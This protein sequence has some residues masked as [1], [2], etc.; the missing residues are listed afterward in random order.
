MGGSWCQSML[1]LSLLIS[2]IFAVLAYVWSWLVDV[3]DSRI[4][5]EW[6]QGSGMFWSVWGAGISTAQR[7]GI[8]MMDQC[9]YKQDA[10]GIVTCGPKGRFYPCKGN[11][12]V[13]DV[14]AQGSIASLHGNMGIGH[15]ISSWNVAYC[16]TISHSRELSK[17]RS[18]TIL[19]QLTLRN[20]FCSRTSLAFSN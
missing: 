7:T 12:M 10:C 2:A 20:R 11:G 4:I 14:F 15:C 17:F 16:S 1:F 6:P 19:R 13:R 18:P 8:T 3:R 9:I 5:V